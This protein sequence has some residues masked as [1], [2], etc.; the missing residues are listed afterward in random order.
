MECIICFEEITINNYKLNCGH[1]YHLDCLQTHF[2]II[3]NNINFNNNKLNCPTCRSE[4]DIKQ[5]KY[6]FKKINY[7]IKKFY[8]KYLEI[9]NSINVNDINLLKSYKLEYIN[10]IVDLIK[11]KDSNFII[12]VNNSNMNIMIQYQQL[13]L[14]IEYFN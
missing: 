12:E 4:C 10:Q 13:V 7:I 6:T 2:N 5:G 14:I 3:I 8:K 11:K 1:E 9:F